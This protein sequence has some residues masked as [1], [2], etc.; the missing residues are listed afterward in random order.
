[1]AE[2][3]LGTNLH[4][5][6]GKRT[7]LLTPLGFLA[8]QLLIVARVAVNGV[9]FFAF[10]AF[11]LVLLWDIAAAVLSWRSDGKANAVILYVPPTIFA[12]G[13]AV[14]SALV[15]PQKNYMVKLNDILVQDVAV[16]MICF[17]AV[18]LLYGYVID[19]ESDKEKEQQ[20]DGL[21]ERRWVRILLAAVAVVI[22]AA[23]IVWGKVLGHHD[24]DATLS[25]FGVQ[26]HELVKVIFVLL[27]GSLLSSETL[28]TPAKLGWSF[29]FVV[30]CCASLV[31]M[32]EFGTLLVYLMVYLLSL[33]TVVDYS[34]V[35]ISVK[36]AFEKKPVRII[37]I[38][39]AAVL[40]L[41][42]L[43]FYD[44]VK[45]AIESKYESRILPWIGL[46]NSEHKQRMTYAMMNGGWFGIWNIRHFVSVPVA[47]SDVTYI[48]VLQFFGQLGGLALMA[49]Y[50]L[51]AYCSLREVVRWREDSKRAYAVIAALMISS[52]AFVAIGSA[53]GLLPLIGL[54]TPLIS[55]GG[56]SYMTTFVLL[57]MI[58]RS[59]YDFCT[60]DSYQKYVTRD[61]QTN[62]D[63]SETARDSR[64]ARTA[65][66]A[67][68]FRSS[69]FVRVLLS[70]ICVI[71]LAALLVT[72]AASHWIDQKYAL[73]QVEA[74]HTEEWSDAP[75]EEVADLPLTSQKHVKNILLLGTDTDSN[76]T[77]RSDAIMLVSLNTKTD[78]IKL[79][80][81]QRDN[82]VAIPG[83]KD[84]HKLN[85]AYAYGGAPLVMQTIQNN[86]RIQIDNYVEMDMDGFFGLV[87]KLDKVTL[88]VT[89]AE[90]AYINQKTKSHLAAGTVDLTPQEAL[91]YVRARKIAGSNGDF[92]RT[93][94]Q[95]KALAAI[96]KELSAML[97]ARQYRQLNEV[98][99]VIVG[100]V[101]TGLSE[102]E[103]QEILPD[104]LL[105]VNKMAKSDSFQSESVPFGKH[106]DNIRKNGVD[107][108]EPQLQENDAYICEYL[109]E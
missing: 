10:T 33:C 59:H 34:H 74:L 70:V 54:T 41:L 1:M 100:T 15:I 88:T 62:R 58:T 85:S 8:A 81:F 105:A 2:K 37:A 48:M 28:G 72:L 11:W 104:L 31:I 108:I 82:Y 47:Q 16:A 20:K 19:R 75:V 94:R 76:D 64:A 51:Y 42:C 43:I 89:E 21:M 80:S 103:F 90:A 24:N 4:L 98:I 96:S 9:G 44:N 109:Y 93:E 14:Q 92:G 23:T 73:M 40:L 32:N 63:I 68:F 53:T 12:F 71:S 61:Q 84:K 69:A 55:K 107:Y 87:E 29:L 57:A 26:M 27:L 39:A 67:D 86:F 52:Q 91:T 60:D 45:S 83:K 25:L 22:Y 65:A 17:A 38:V 18:F 77:K 46:T 95:R 13:V 97:K 56:M 106:Y 99:D 50:V 5:A 30:M 78:T 79:L 102:D 3:R 35:R 36:G 66:V 49:L 6:E 7:Q 101:Q